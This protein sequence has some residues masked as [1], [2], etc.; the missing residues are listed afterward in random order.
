MAQ[1]AEPIVDKTQKNL[2]LDRF[3]HSSHTSKEPAIYDHFQAEK[4]ACL[5]IAIPEEII[6]FNK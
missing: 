6:R 4:S 3:S 1:G 2:R 5:G